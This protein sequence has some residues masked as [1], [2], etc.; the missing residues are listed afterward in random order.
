MLSP[1]TANADGCS[2]LCQIEGPQ[3]SD[4][5]MP[6]TVAS[7]RRLRFV[8]V[9]TRPA[10]G[11][12]LPGVGSDPLVHG[13]TL[14]LFDSNAGPAGAG[15]VEYALRA[16]GWKGLGTAE[17]ASGFA[18]RGGASDP[19]RAVLI[20]IHGLRIFCRG[21]AMTLN[22]P[23]TG[24]LAVNLTLGTASK[25]YCARFGGTTIKNEVAYM[26]R[27]ESPAPMSCPGP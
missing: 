3:E 2:A 24:D 25:R 11:Y 27:T 19:C 15:S 7:V 18:Y 8:K 21:A 1:N 26:K 4:E 6:G 13:A 5:L 20:T 9:N 16:A 14:R 17:G 12:H 23:F 10:A 22:P